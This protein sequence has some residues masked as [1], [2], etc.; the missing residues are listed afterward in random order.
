MFRRL[1]EGF[2]MERTYFPQGQEYYNTLPNIIP[3]ATSGLPGL[4]KAIA[5]VAQTTP[6]RYQ[7]YAVPNPNQ[8]VQPLVSPAIAKAAA[9]CAAGNIDDLIR[10][11]D[12]NNPNGCG[13]VYSPPNQ[14]SPYPVVSRGAYGAS[15]GPNPT[16]D[17]P[18]YKKWF[19]DLQEAKKQML[20]DKCKAL[21]ACTDVDSAVFNGVCGFCTDINQGVPVDAV[22]KPLYTDSRI[23][24][25]T[26]VNDKSQC[27][28]PQQING[29]QPILDRT[30]E[31]VNGRLS[32]DCLHQTVIS[33]G[34]NKN[35]ALALALKDGQQ[36]IARL[37]TDAAVQTYNRFANP[38][39][40]ISLF[41]DANTTRN[42]VLQEV[43]KLA[44]NATNPATTGLGAAAR[45]LCLNRGAINGY[46]ACSELSDASGPP[47]DMKCLQDFFLTMGGNRQGTAYPNPNNMTNYN[48]MANLGRIKQ[49]W[50]GLFAKAK[51]TDGY[52]DYPEQQKAAKAAYGTE[53]QNQIK[54]AP[55]VKGVEVFWFVPQVMSPNRVTGFLRRTIEQKIVQF[56]TDPAFANTGG[57]SNVPQIGGGGYGCMLQLTDLRSPVDFS[58]T[59]DVLVDDGFWIAVNQP[60]NIDEIAMTQPGYTIDKPGL[61]E[62][63][64]LQGPTRY[65][66]GACTPFHSSSPNIMKLY[67][68]DAGGGWSAFTF[69]MNACVGTPQIDS[70]YLSLTCELRGPFLSFEVTKRGKWEETR[71]PGLFSQITP[72]TGLDIHTR[73]DEKVGVPGKKSF[74]RLNTASS[75]IDLRNIAFQSWKNITI[76]TRFNEMPV[77]ESII[78]LACGPPGTYYFNVIATPISGDIAK[79]HIEYRI[80]STSREIKTTFAIRIGIWH[81]FRIKNNGTGFSLYC[82]TISDLIASKGARDSVVNVTE[83][84]Q[85]WGVNG[86]WNPAPGQTYEV[87]DIMLGTAGYSGWTAM[88]G[89]SAFTYDVAWVHFFDNDEMT[90]DDVFRDASADWMYTDFPSEYNVYST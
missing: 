23:P 2:D 72:L 42:N 63:L 81:I 40:N 30:C 66:S 84:T 13:W 77:R 59:F 71:N 8:I 39:L 44:A 11:K 64:G 69:K 19:F 25:T 3:S 43:R 73:T 10:A 75:L 54:R 32:L 68:E 67:H 1:A 83:N 51:G 5:T 76:A 79:I 87:A 55:P 9:E 38:L 37:A 21:Q 82:D 65:R 16:F 36:S 89:S 49:Y 4:D 31:P 52:V 29:P 14:G 6:S 46:N 47:Y 80:G 78:N 41:R 88:Y 35:G 85:L 74:V 48:T 34:C 28:P 17:P 58:A 12:S 62:N 86:T 27:P 18:A 15:D 45:D 56:P 24:C 22:G 20:I 57:P 70:N 60:A 53:L 61:F 7:S 33:G 26:I 90:N 50:S